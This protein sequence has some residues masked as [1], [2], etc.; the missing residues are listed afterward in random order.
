MTADAKNMFVVAITA[1]AVATVTTFAAQ[2]L[3]PPIGKAKTGRYRVDQNGR[4]LLD[5]A[6]G[7]SWRYS[8]DGWISL[9]KG[10]K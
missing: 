10:G 7:Q 4:L 2:S 3:L 5:T 6:T 1:A 8:N 9:G